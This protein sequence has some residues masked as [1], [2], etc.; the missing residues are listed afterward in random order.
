[1]PLVRKIVA[2]I[3]SVGRE[4]RSLWEQ[5]RDGELDLSSGERRRA[6]EVVKE[7]ESYFRELDQIGCSFRSPDFSLGLVDFP[8]V[9]E[10][11]LVHLC[12]RSD[13]EELLYYHDP[14]VGFAGR[15]R[16]PAELLAAE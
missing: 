15:K 7:L 1:M 8:A 10:D 14:R 11:Q 4:L 3:L 13:E 9:I 5:D 12:W 6:E 2:D 16:I